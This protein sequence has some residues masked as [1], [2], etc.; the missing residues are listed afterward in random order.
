[1]PVGR[2]RAFDEAVALDKALAVF[3]QL[4]YEGTTLPDLTAAMGINRPSLY[5]AFGNKDALFRK[6]LAR[7]MEQAGCLMR[8]ALQEPT[9]RE[10]VV[11]L[12]HDSISQVNDAGKPRGCFLVQSALACGEGADAIKQEVIKQR[13]AGQ[14]ALQA[15]FKKAIVEGE[16]P[17]DVNP[18]DLARFVSTVMQGLAVQAT[19]GASKKE[20]L[21]VAEIAMRAW[22]KK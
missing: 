21:R 4:G 11:K 1:M 5:A 6:A 2:P 3:W 12:L 10:T 14:A 22:P 19:S 17:K 8:T 7:Y 15:R 9:A 16:L 20:L 13:F 18:A